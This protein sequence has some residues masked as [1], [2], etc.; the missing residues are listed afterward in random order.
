M[1]TSAFS[2]GSVAATRRV[3]QWTAR[4]LGEASVT[5]DGYGDAPLTGAWPSTGSESVHWTCSGLGRKDRS[6]PY[7]AAVT[8]FIANSEFV[9][10]AALAEEIAEATSDLRTFD[11]AMAGEMAPL[12]TVLLRSESVASSQI[13][14]LSVSARALAEAEIGE[15]TREKATM[16]AANVAAM[17]A[18]IDLSDRL[19]ADSI[20][21]MHAALM[22]GQPRIA[23]KWRGE[24][25]WIGGSSY[26]PHE[27]DYVAPIHERVPEA[28]QDLTEFMRREDMPALAQAAIAHAHFET[29]H[30]FPDGNGRTG[31]ALISAMLRHRRTTTNITAPIS[32]GLLAHRDDYFDALV[33]YRDGRIEPIIH[34]MARATSDSVVGGQA[35]IADL[36]N[37]RTEWVAKIQARADSGAHR[38]ADYLIRQP[39]VTMPM[40]REHLDIPQVGAHRHLQRLVDDGVLIETSGKSRNRIWRAPDVLEALDD[41]AASAGRRPRP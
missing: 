39:V 5:L 9:L 31:R 16:I 15:S 13:E 38:L 2:P 32:S 33:A 24:Q 10:P 20:L 28:I 17:R 18:A 36:K 6:G 37:I 29:I 40:V 30:P 34:E 23:G 8:P 27:A 12:S 4:Q 11:E 19:D 21:A 1:N 25:V 22:T 14:G 26:S 35:L 7:E 41:Y 3:G